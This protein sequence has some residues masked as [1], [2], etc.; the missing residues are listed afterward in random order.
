MS[1][2]IDRE[3]VAAGDALAPESSVSSASCPVRPR[4]G[5]N[6]GDAGRTQNGHGSASR[7]ALGTHSGRTHEDPD[8]FWAT[9]PTEPPAQMEP[10]Q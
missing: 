1:E 3:A 6:P 4:P 9:T 7:D 10:D 8:D 2:H 5:V